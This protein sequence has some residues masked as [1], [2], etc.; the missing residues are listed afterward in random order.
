MYA[1]FWH[2]FGWWYAAWYYSYMWAEILELDVF[3][4]I[5]ELW[6]FDEKTGKK[7]FKTIIWQWTKKKAKELFFDFMWREPSIKAFLEKYWL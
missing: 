7:L 4:K 3:T 6:M 5:K 2:I 1:S